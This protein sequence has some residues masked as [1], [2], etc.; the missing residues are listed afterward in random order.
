MASPHQ[1]RE[2]TPI[3]YRPAHPYAD[4]FGHEWAW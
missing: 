4:Q 2:V 1:P 3:W